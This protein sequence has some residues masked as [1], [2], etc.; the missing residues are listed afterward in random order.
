MGSTTNANTL[1]LMS[2]FFVAKTCTTAVQ[3]IF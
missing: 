2:V 1:L 3:T